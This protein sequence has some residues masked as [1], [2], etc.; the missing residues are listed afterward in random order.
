M[1]PHPGNPREVELLERW[2][3]T[4]VE[5]LPSASFL[6]YPGF[7]E[8]TFVTTLHP[9]T[10]AGRATARRTGVGLYMLALAVVGA[11][12]YR[13]GI[14][15]GAIVAFVIAIALVVRGLHLHRP[16]V[17]V[18]GVLSILCLSLAGL[19]YTTGHTHVGLVAMAVSGWILMRP[20]SSTPQP[21]ERARIAD[22]VQN[23]V[24]D[25]LAPF[26]SNSSKSYFYNATGTAAI[27]Y[28]ARAGIA[29]VSGDPIGE[30]AAFDDLLTR[31]TLFAAEHGWR[32]AVLAASE[33][34]TRL[35]QTGRPGRP[36]L[37]AVCIGRDVVVDVQ[38]FSMQGR[39]FRNVRQA[40]Q[41]TRNCGVSTEI[42]AEGEL[43]A[44]A[45]RQLLELVA[46]V[47]A[48]HQRRGFSMILD[49]LLDGVHPNTMLVIAR[50]RYGCPV[51]F[52]RYAVA[53]H[54]REWSLDVPWRG[55][56]APN[57]TDERMIVD[58]VDHVRV[59]GGTTVSLA[60]APFPELFAR[61]VTGRRDHLLRAMFH[62]TS[63]LVALESLY[64]YLDKFHAAAGRRFV[65]FEL[66]CAVPAVFAM[67]T[68]EFVPH[69]E[70]DPPL[71]QRQTVHITDRTG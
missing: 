3:R 24:G 55:T 29:V 23:S 2:Q 25:P 56:R 66:R 60:F 14:D 20:I 33:Y 68:F 52:Q 17:A 51:A 22:L 9:T 7:S 46:S 50:D 47:R 71:P 31:F 45:R 36:R 40:V 4:I 10:S 34:T 37:R 38:R 28:R 27:A 67:L 18:H 32:V 70:H 6:H 43:S 59:R 42:L 39:P 5:L 62:L 53:D 21:G 65:L 64:R 63:A 26:V 49:H 15:L 13:S 1:D 69:R 41:R 16:V 61:P 44:R 8:A 54:G 35:W 19:A 48:G 58:V 11:V 57:G 12:L 30:V